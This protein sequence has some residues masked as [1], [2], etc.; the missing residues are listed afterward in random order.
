MTLMDLEPHPRESEEKISLHDLFVTS[1]MTFLQEN[2]NREG[3]ASLVKSMKTTRLSVCR[4]TTAKL[5]FASP[6]TA[7]RR[8]WDHTRD[9]PFEGPVQ[10]GLRHHAPPHR[11]HKRHLRTSIIPTNQVRHTRRVFYRNAIMTRVLL[12]RSQL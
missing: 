3:L 10:R 1:G 7:E 12:R 2:A 9:H 4:S 5:T 11:I 8:Y 6:S